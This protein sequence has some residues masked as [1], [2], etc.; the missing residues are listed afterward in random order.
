MLLALRRFGARVGFRDEFRDGCGRM[1]RDGGR[2]GGFHARHRWVGRYMRAKY[3]YH[4]WNRMRYSLYALVW[5]GDKAG[6]K[7]V[8]VIDVYVHAGILTVL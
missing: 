2:E 6:V 1:G 5:S 3:M 7:V 4:Q 8:N